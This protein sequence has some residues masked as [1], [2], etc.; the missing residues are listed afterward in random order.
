[1]KRFSPQQSLLSDR[2]SGL[3]IYDRSRVPFLG[4]ATILL[5]FS[6]VLPAKA[7][8]IIYGR[9]VGPDVVFTIS[10][11][12][13]PG[14]PDE[15]D[16][17]GQEVRFAP[18]IGVF[19]VA[20]AIS[21]VN[22]FGLDAAV[23][24]GPGGEINEPTGSGE[25]FAIFGQ[26]LYIGDTYVPGTAFDTT[27]TLV[28]ETL[29][30]LGVDV[31]GGPYVWTTTNS[32]ATVTMQFTPPPVVVAPAD[33]SALKASLAKKIKKLKKKV[34][35]AKRKGQSAKAKRLLKKVRK[36]QRNRRALA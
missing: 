15:T 32:G 30:T 3:R 21:G 5:L 19:E 18:D 10:G 16:E 24:F 36:T 35:Q 28:G 23:P 31:A 6:A 14:P 7:Q 26:H 25:I 34:K 20:E 12:F 1:M 17:F 9:E 11:S 22:R 13:D 33:N 8:L 29:L 4:L 2:A 27:M